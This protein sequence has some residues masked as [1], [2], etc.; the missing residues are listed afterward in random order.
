MG[1]LLTFRT[2]RTVGAV[3]ANLTQHIEWYQPVGELTDRCEQCDVL[4]SV[5]YALPV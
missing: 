2:H 3:S 4:S 5:C 1:V